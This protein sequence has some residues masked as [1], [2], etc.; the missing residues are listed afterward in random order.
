MVNPDDNVEDEDVELKKK[1]DDPKNMEFIWKT[2]RHFAW[3]FFIVFIVGTYGL[4]ISKIAGSLLANNDSN[5][6]NVCQ[7]N[8][9]KEYKWK[10]L[11]G[12]WGINM[13]TEPIK[14]PETDDPKE[15]WQNIQF[16][17]IKQFTF[18]KFSDNSSTD[19]ASTSKT[20]NK[21][22]K[23]SF[24]KNIQEQFNSLNNAL[25]SADTPSSS[26]DKSYYDT[27]IEW[28]TKDWFNYPKTEMTFE[29]YSDTVFDIFGE[30][31]TSV[32]FNTILGNLSDSAIRFVSILYLPIVYLI[33][34]FAFLCI[35]VYIAFKTTYLSVFE[36]KFEY[37]F[38]GYKTTW[39]FVKHFW[40][41]IIYAFIYPIYYLVIFP[42]IQTYKYTAPGGACNN[43]SDPPDNEPHGF[44]TFLMDT[45]WSHKYPLFY[46]K[47]F[48]SLL[49]WLITIS[50]SFVY[51]GLPQGLLSLVL[52]GI[53]FYNNG[54]SSNPEQYYGQIGSNIIDRLTETAAA[55][56]GG[57]KGKLVSKY[58]YTLT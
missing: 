18:F 21:N 53:M 20:A 30:I 31:L 28:F 56:G 22:S 51:L 49:F 43:L 58:T 15:C 32:F 52:L 57:K 4:Y 17:P 36:D 13:F 27:I 23:K 39:N 26:K 33:Y 8:T 29:K 41:A 48:A 11:A 45:I 16:E 19:S 46:N 25:N 47:T 9:I 2:L 54:F 5:G 7:I 12:L 34:F 40:F 37:S 1:G 38:L 24:F 44:G 10:G 42:I 3:V 14:D 35:S 50:N 55:V 6:P